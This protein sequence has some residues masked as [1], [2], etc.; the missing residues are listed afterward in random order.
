MTTKTYG[1]DL[2][3]WYELAIPVWQRILKES[4]EAGDKRREEYARWMLNTVLE[5]TE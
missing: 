4:Q 3:R 5:V 2:T 1:P